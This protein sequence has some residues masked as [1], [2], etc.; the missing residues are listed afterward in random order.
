MGPALGASLPLR[1]GSSCAFLRARVR[2]FPARFRPPSSAV[3]PLAVLRA[4]SCVGRV[5]ARGRVPGVV[6]RQQGWAAL[7]LRAV[8]VHHGQGRSSARS[9]GS[10]FLARSLRRH[11]GVLDVSVHSREGYHRDE[12]LSSA[13]PG[14]KAA[15]RAPLASVFCVLLRAH[16]RALHATQ[17]VARRTRTHDPPEHRTAAAAGP[18]PPRLAGRVHAW[19]L[20]CSCSAVLAVSRPQVPSGPAPQPDSP[21]PTRHSDTPPRR[22]GRFTVSDRSLT[23]PDGRRDA[24][25]TQTGRRDAR[26]RRVLARAEHGPTARVGRGLV[27][28]GH[29]GSRPLGRSVSAH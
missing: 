29:S 19:G 8:V 3:S 10:A 5:A 17:R 9:G 28:S 22:D 12:R 7:G 25:R 21:R 11:S 26:A 23:A 13:F 14:G 15:G 27:C 6:R 18:R 4:S 20:F 2:V 16:P 24:T 1:L